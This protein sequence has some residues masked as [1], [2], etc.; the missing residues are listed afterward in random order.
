[1]EAPN[2]REATLATAAAL[3]I[4]AIADHGG[5]GPD[6]DRFVLATEPVA[7][8]AHEHC[9]VSA[10]T[11]AISVELVEHDV[12]EPVC[13]RDD[14]AVE[15]ALPRHQKL[16]HHEIREQDVRLCLLDAIAFLLTFLPGVARKRRP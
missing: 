8:A 15:R 11:P 12:V 6:A 9:H 14:G 3:C 13:I 10:L 2:R 4:T 5:G 16:E 7:H 1:M